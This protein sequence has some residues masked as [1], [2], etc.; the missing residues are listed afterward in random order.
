[1]VGVHLVDEYS[2]VLST[3]A[4]EVSLP[5]TIDIQLAHYPPTLDRKFPDCRSDGLTVPRDFAW[6]ADVH[7]E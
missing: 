3:V 4:G 5:V 2:P 6:K 1:M 7:G